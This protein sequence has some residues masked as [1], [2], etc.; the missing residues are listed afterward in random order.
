MVFHKVSAQFKHF[1]CR[2]D[3]LYLVQHSSDLIHEDEMLDLEVQTIL[4]SNR[5]QGSS[6][7]LRDRLIF[8]DDQ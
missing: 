5:D 8:Y 3:T 2:C 7:S 6:V 1:F 4:M